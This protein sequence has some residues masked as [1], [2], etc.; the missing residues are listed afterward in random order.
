MFARLTYPLV[1]QI[2][3]VSLDTKLDL[4]LLDFSTLFENALVT[5]QK[6]SLRQLSLK[7]HIYQLSSFVKFF[8]HF[9]DLLHTLCITSSCLSSLSD[10]A[11]SEAD[12]RIAII[13]CLALLELQTWL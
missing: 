8:P 1:D 4:S 2:L 10:I 7:S 6:F 5:F 11:T 13:V 9:F 12:I 3:I